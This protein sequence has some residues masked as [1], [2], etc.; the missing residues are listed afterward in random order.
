MIALKAI[1]GLGTEGDCSLPSKSDLKN[2][3]AFFHQEKVFTTDLKPRAWSLV[4]DATAIAV[5]ADLSRASERSSGARRLRRAASTGRT[6][7]CTNQPRFTVKENPC[8]GGAVHT[9]HKA[10]I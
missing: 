6:H 4:E 1:F 2:Q 7:G 10:D 9:W 5:C 8:Q 3:I